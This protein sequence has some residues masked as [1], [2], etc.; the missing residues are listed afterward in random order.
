VHTGRNCE[1]N[2]AVANIYV[3]RP[4]PGDAIARLSTSHAVKI[5]DGALPPEP[6]VL[7]AELHDSEGLLC[8]LTDRIDRQLL[9]AAPRL[10]AI[11]NYAVGSDNID[12][13]A[14]RERGIAVGVTP[15]VLT[16]A[17]ADLAFTLLLAAARHIV[18]A[19]TAVRAGEWVTWESDRWL[20]SDVHGAT[21]GII[22]FGRIG[23]AVAER[24]A[25][26]GMT[27]LATRATP[28]EELLERSDYVSLH[29]P[30]TA[31]TRHLIDAAALKRMRSNAI[32]INTA[33]GAI[34]DGPALA[35][36]LHAGA[37]AG[38]ALDVSDPEPIAADDPL[39]S[40]P[41]V[42]VVPHI[43]S[44]TRRTRERM[45]EMA[46]EN[47]TAALEGRPMPHAAA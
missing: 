46:V 19:A 30:L 27:V 10:R 22:G 47:L 6:S 9:D 29:C 38:A 14:A 3:T 12:L 32:L 42:I 7:R 34:V 11:A 33:R 8:M 24:A 21:L 13:A 2:A 25:G 31:Q 1:E 39:L 44:A 5:W 40:A 23:Q 26:F 43:G 37:I 17:T 35:A 4:I 18:E 45:S 15:D 16:N 36:A 20:G 28:L 41:N